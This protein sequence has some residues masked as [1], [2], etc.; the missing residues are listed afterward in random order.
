MDYA[1]RKKMFLNFNLLSFILGNLKTS[2]DVN[3]I[4]STDVFSYTLHNCQPI[5]F[6]FSFI[7]FEL[8]MLSKLSN[9]FAKIKRKIIQRE[10][11]FSQLFL[12]CF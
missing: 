7:S 5:S 11:F 4:L 6:P 9:N 1:V 3:S 10:I 12:F 2:I 8:S